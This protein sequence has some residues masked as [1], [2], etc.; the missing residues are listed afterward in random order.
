MAL[1]DWVDRFAVWE[2]FH[3]D[4]QTL[5][6]YGAGIALYAALVFTVYQNISRRDPL[7][8][9]KGKGWSA[10]II[11]SAETILTFPILSFGYFAVLSLSLFL[12]AKPAT[13]TAHILLLS[14]AAVLG[15]RVTA[16]LSELMSN[17]IAKLMPL[18]L[19]AVVL[20]DPGYLSP[21]T[22]LQRVGEAVWM[23]PVLLQYFVLFILVEA[24][25]RG[26][27]RFAPSF[28]KV[29]KKVEHRR[30]LSK[31]AMLKDIEG[32]H[33]GGGLFHRSAFHEHGPRDRSG[34][35]LAVDERT[36]GK[37]GSNQGVGPA[38]KHEM[39]AAHAPPAPHEH[40]PRAGP[41]GKGGK[42]GAW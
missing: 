33:H 16:H 3:P 30:H 35:F 12:M 7:H 36:G 15:V 27:R 41:G 8:S 29:A 14:M 4:L 11:R 37:P 23:A 18:S 38:I 10:R 42:L 22:T 32:E 40:K 6:I 13:E 24:V 19:L 9:G 31:R 28:S 5:L 1:I 21:A 25:L 17:D 39:K 26:V 20:V 34:D 2:G